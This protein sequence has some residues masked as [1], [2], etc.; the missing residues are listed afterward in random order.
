MSIY[1]HIHMPPLREPFGAPLLL[2]ES[3]LWYSYVYYSE[4][5]I[6]KP[7]NIPWYTAQLI[8]AILKLIYKF[9]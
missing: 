7:Y 4:A 1:S 6:L 8:I 5:G 3:L 2:M 9:N